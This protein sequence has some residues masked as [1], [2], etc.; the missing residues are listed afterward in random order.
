LVAHA[1]G[2]YV[3]A[4]ERLARVDVLVIDDWGPQAGARGQSGTICS[5]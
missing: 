3:R 1:D 5:K 4:L 2:S